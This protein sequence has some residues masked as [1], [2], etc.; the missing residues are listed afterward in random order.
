MLCGLRNRGT[1]ICSRSK[2][3]EGGRGRSA[4]GSEAS[5]ERK[6]RSK[7]IAHG[8]GGPSAHLSNADYGGA[9]CGHLP[10]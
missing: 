4:D 7:N 5:A 10:N 9:E 8:R 3:R 1:S 6:P 2:L